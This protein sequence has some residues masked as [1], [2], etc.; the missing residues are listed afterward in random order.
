MYKPLDCYRPGG[1]SSV[2]VIIAVEVGKWLRRRKI[3]SYA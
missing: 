2:T 1:R 3:L